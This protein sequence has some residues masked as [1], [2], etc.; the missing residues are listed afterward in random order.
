MIDC[1]LK[2]VCVCSGSG[3]DF[4]ASCAGKVLLLLYFV[5]AYLH[6]EADIIHALRNSCE[7]GFRRKFP[8]R[9]TG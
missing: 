2:F 9:E 3:I 5:S 6:E 7:R 1:Q 8:E 4:F